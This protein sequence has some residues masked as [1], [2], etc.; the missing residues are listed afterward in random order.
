M[1]D[2]GEVQWKFRKPRAKE[3]FL[4][5]ARMIVLE[6]DPHGIKLP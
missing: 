4:Y 5:S 6:R 2:D 3:R 1:V